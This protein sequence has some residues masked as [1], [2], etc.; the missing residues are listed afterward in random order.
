MLR[1]HSSETTVGNCRNF[2]NFLFCVFPMSTAKC[3]PKQLSS[4]S[5]WT[6]VN[7]KFGAWSLLSSYKWITIC[8]IWSCFHPLMKFCYLNGRA[9]WIVPTKSGIQA[10]ACCLFKPRKGK[11]FSEMSCHPKHKVFGAWGN[12]LSVERTV[13]H[14]QQTHGPLQRKL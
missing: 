2:Q 3:T 7:R 14:R 6:P 13:Y 1:W 5:S 12:G 8:L 9:V 10:I 11:K 4:P